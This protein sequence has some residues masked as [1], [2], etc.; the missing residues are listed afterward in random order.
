MQ[1]ILNYGISQFL[2]DDFANFEAFLHI[3]TAVCSI[4]QQNRW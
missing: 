1:M 3:V 2:N 4:P